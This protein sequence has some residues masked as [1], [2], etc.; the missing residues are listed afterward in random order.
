MRIGREGMPDFVVQARH[1]FGD[2]ILT[3]E[4]ADDNPAQ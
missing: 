2:M 3:K 1:D 4:I